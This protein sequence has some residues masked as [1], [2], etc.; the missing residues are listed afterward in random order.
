MNLSAESNRQIRARKRGLMDRIFRIRARRRREPGVLFALGAITEEEEILEN[1]KRAKEEWLDA[2]MN[3]EYVDDQD[4]VDYYT[5]RILAS[6]VRYE[7]FIRKAK[8][9]GYRVESLE[10]LEGG[11]L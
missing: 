4:I 2:N 11:V 10:K 7:Y 1:L 6:Q 3:F 8:E 5:Y 9:K